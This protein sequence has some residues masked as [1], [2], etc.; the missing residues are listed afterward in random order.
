MNIAA[1]PN[2]YQYASAENLRRINTRAEHT[3]QDITKEV[4]LR[5]KQAKFELIEAI[6]PAENSLYDPE[7]NDCCNVQKTNILFKNILK[8]L[9]A[10]FSKLHVFKIGN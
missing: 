4:K 1:G 3:A 9:N 10:F 2:A 6:M 8:T 5:H 7:V